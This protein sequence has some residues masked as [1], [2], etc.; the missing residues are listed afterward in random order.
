MN[1]TDNSLAYAWH[2]VQGKYSEDLAYKIINFERI[3]KLRLTNVLDICC[4]SSNLL[5]IMLNE[6]KRC[7][8]TE[9]NDEF[10]EFNKKE[11]PSVGYY[12]AESILDIDKFKKFDLITLTNRMVNNIENL[13]DLGR[14]FELVYNHLSNGGV[15]IFDFYTKN[16]LKEWDETKQTISDNIE[17]ITNVKTNGNT[18]TITNTF[19]AKNGVT[20]D[21]QPKY[22]KSEIKDVK[23]HYN[24]ETISTLIKKAKFRYLI[25]TNENFSPIP[26]INSSKTAY[27]IAIKRED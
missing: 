13:N 22:Y 1:N 5:K 11:F 21:G 17:L 19:Y 25:S 4:G 24:N 10:M 8:G 2:K 27:F 14:F 12:K 6:N 20:E 26:N 15:F 9:I 7:F 16:Q 18:S 3:Q 23:H